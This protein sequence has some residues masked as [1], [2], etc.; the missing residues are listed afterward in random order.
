[1][2]PTAPTIPAVPYLSASVYKSPALKYQSWKKVPPFT[3]GGA[4]TMYLLNINAAHVSTVAPRG[5]NSN[6]IFAVDIT[7]LDDPNDVLCDGLD[8]WKQNDCDK[9]WYNKTKDLNGGAKVTKVTKTIMSMN[10]IALKSSCCSLA[11][12]LP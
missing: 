6:C 10:Q 11:I 2:A 8:T 12:R 5:L 3:R 1:M 4:E 9:K 7:E